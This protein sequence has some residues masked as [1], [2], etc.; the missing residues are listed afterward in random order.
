[1]GISSVLAQR[2][3]R[4]AGH[5]MRA[6]TILP[7]RLPSPVANLDVA[8]FSYKLTPWQGADKAVVVSIIFTCTTAVVLEIKNLA[9][10]RRA[11]SNNCKMIPLLLRQFPSFRT[12]HVSAPECISAIRKT[13]TNKNENRNEAVTSSYVKVHVVG[14]DDLA[15]LCHYRCIKVNTER[16]ELSSSQHLNGGAK[17]VLC[18]SFLRS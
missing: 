10:P 4:F 15:H 9:N 3:A 7:W 5:C 12:Q 2:R 16:R 1:M 17:G 8:P 13:M 18:S 11:S 14:A 6:S